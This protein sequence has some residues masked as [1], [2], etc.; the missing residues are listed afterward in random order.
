VGKLNNE[1]LNDLNYS[2]NIIRVIK[3]RRM[4]WAGLAARLG[5][6]RIVYRVLVGKPE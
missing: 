5:E 1:E 2:P 3:K 4:R 6:K